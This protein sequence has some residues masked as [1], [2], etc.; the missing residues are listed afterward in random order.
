MRA[1]LKNQGLVLKDTGGD[2]QVIPLTNADQ[3]T[4]FLKK[5]ID[6]AWTVEPWVS[7]LVLNAHGK[8]FFEESTLW[9]GG[10]YATALVVVRKKFL[11]EHPELVRKFLEAHKE[12]TDFLQKNPAEA[13]RLFLEEI[14][15]ETQKKFPPGVVDQ[16]FSRVRYT[17]D[18]LQKSV[19]QQAEMAFEAGFL[20]KRPD[21][22][23]LF[24]LKLLK[25]ISKGK[26]CSE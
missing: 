19:R 18:P 21:L 4:L 22:T 16:A 24:D 7:M 6:A 11:D 15:K 1:W 5:E 25:E 3:Q 9:E 12:I 17:C 13:K 14:E 10:D 23:G 8:I 2:V 26:C 20:K